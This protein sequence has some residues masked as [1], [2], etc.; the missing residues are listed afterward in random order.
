[1]S[2]ADYPHV[3]QP[4]DVRHKTLKHRINFGSH[5]A[6]MS[7]MGLPSE[8][9]LG[10]YTERAR[11]GAA[12]ISVEPMPTDA[13]AV[14]T[15]GNFRHSSDDVIPGFRAITDACHEYGT[16]MIHQ[17][18]HVGQHG[19]YMNS[20]LPYLSPSGMPSYHDSFGSMTMT[21]ADIDYNDR[22]ICAGRQTGES[23]RVR[24]G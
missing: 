11:G 18:Y 12:L 23:L 6:N 19:D 15:R 5:T 13:Y 22:G 20:F 21:E 24:R 7:D 9:H 2:E 10:Y 17:L 14:L 16:V 8:R 3:F 4:L 1:M